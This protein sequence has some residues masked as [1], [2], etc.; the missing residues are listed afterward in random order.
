M[1]KRTHALTTALAVCALFF[2]HVGPAAASTLNNADREAAV[3]V[4]IDA[5]FLRPVGLGVL[6]VGTV[7]YGL[8]APLM[9]ITRPTDMGKPFQQLVVAPARYTF[10][11]PLGMH[12]P[13][14]SQ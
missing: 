2:T 11:D 6:V 12:P 8:M 3:P 13:Q 7:A 14:A 9:A 5:V 4:V 1:M 10:V